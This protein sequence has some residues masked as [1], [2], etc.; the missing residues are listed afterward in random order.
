MLDDESYSI[1][2]F[3][4]SIAFSAAYSSHGMDAEVLSRV[5]MA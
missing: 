4:S 5:K 2:D 3:H 1:A